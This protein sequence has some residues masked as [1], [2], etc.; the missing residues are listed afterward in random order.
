MV[1]NC[2]FIC[3]MFLLLSCSQKTFENKEALWT[4]LKEADNGYLQEKN[5]NGYNFSLLYK[6]TDL[7]VLQELEEN[8]TQQSIKALREKYKKQLYFTLSMS[9]NGKE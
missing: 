7:L 6:P 3:C 4:Y 5:I 8:P 1:K 9:K 2:L